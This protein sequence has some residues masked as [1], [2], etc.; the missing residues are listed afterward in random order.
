[1]VMFGGK[2]DW[3]GLER[4]VRAVMVWRPMERRDVVMCLPT[5]PAAWLC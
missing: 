2:V 5:L 3:L 1:M 4:W